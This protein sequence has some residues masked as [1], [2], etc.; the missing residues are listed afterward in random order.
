MKTISKIFWAVA[1]FVMSLTGNAQEKVLGTIEAY[2]IQISTDKTTNII[3]PYGIVGVDRGNRHI[4]VQKAKG[5]EN[6]LQVK[7]ANDS[8]RE[9]NLSVIT[10][11]GKLNSFIVSY[12]KQPVLL[13]VS[14]GD[15]A[16]KGAI[17]LSPDQIDQAEILACSKQVL[18]SRKRVGGIHEK[19][20]G[21]DFRLDGIFIHKNL[22]YF[23][24]RIENQSNIGY[25][26]DQLR[27]YILDQKKA[28]R[29]ASQ[30]VEI[31]PVNLFNNLTK[32]LPRERNTVVVALPK[33]TIPD[34]KFLAIQLMENNGGRHLELVIKNRILFKVNQITIPTRR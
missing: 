3:F 8:I 12:A 31:T 4:L 11:D 2:R 10:S 20:F 32:I 33:F 30:E 5:A 16:R 7:A 9:S 18:H 15:D 28:K 22:M 6:I 21:I 25:D 17:F 19:N 1:L 24:M 34:K 27:F 26:V 29:T 13:N 14:L 23:R